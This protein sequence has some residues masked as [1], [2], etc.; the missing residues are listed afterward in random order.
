MPNIFQCFDITPNATSWLKTKLPSTL[1]FAFEK[2]DK[3][4]VRISND[5]VA[6][7][8]KKAKRVL[9]FSKITIKTPINHLI[10]NL[11]FNVWNVTVKQ[12]IG[13]WAWA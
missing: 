11:Y 7:Y 13:A 12:E 10:E 4:F 6:Y 1:D 9:G 5:S 8:W 2:T 3:C